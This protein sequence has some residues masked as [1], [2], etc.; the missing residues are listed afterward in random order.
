MSA[1]FTSAS[2]PWHGGLHGARA[3]ARPRVVDKRADIWAFGSVL[4][5]ML[6]GKHAFDEAD[7]TEMIAAVVRAEPDWSAL[8]E[9]TPPRLR[10][11][12][13]RCLEKDP[14]Q[15]LREAR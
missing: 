8:P 10:A 7:A 14:K 1:A 3:G 15:R 13:K 5:E 11:L 2:H 6:T 9:S 12:L 4:F